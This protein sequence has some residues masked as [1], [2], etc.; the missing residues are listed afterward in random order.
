[1]GTH[2]YELEQQAWIHFIDFLDDCTGELYIY[3]Q[4]LL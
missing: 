4:E 1:M 2:S 3:L